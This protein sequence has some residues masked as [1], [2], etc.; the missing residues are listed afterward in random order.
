[1]A[2]AASKQTPASK[3]AEAEAP[4]KKAV[5]APPPAPR[6]FE[7]VE[8]KSAKFWE[9]SRQGCDVTVRYG[10][11]GANGQSQTKSFAGEEAAEAHVQKL[12]EEKTE[13]GYQELEGN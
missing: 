5:S 3:G 2:P 1:M 11:I 6:H 7:L 10:R 9:I 4:K 13:K 8:G 12:I